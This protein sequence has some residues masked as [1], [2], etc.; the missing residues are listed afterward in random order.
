MT[1]GNTDP[2]ALDHA[3][4]GLG[5]ILLVELQS[6]TEPHQCH[7]LSVRTQTADTHELFL[8]PVPPSIVLSSEL[9]MFVAR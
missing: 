5:V 7:F 2:D 4:F 3:P 8:L 9:T 1:I 6:P